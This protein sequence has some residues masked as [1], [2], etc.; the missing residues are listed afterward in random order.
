MK[1]RPPETAADD[2]VTA[3]RQT[4]LLDAGCPE[5]AAARIARDYRFDLHRL[6]DLREQGCPFDLAVR[7]LAPLDD[8]PER[9]S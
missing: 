9:S 7:I 6:I 5:A 4:Q 3:W 8:S 1:L 2:Q